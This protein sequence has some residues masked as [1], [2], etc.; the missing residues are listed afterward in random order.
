M[1]VYR[2]GLLGSCHVTGPGLRSARAH[3]GRIGGI[4]LFTTTRTRLSAGVLIAA[5]GALLTPAMTAG[6]TATSI[7]INK[8]THTVTTGK[9]A[10]QFGN[11]TTN[12]PNDPER[13]DS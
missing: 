5:T 11:S 12:P 7:K 4:G 8:T 1:R 10:I 3:L 6:S 2:H 9:F 13:I